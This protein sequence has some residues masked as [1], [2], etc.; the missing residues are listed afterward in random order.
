MTGRERGDLAA[1]AAAGG[2]AGDLLGQSHRQNLGGVPPSRP[3][4][5]QHV[6]GAATRVGLPHA[7]QQGFELVG[8]SVEGRGGSHAH[9]RES[10]TQH[11]C[12][13]AQDPDQSFRRLSPLGGAGGSEVVEDGGKVEVDTAQSSGITAATHCLTETTVVQVGAPTASADIRLGR[14]WYHF[15]AHPR[16]SD[17][18]D[19]ARS[20][21]LQR[22]KGGRRTGGLRMGCG[23]GKHPSADGQPVERG[24]VY[25]PCAGPSAARQTVGVTVGMSRTAGGY[26]VGF[27]CSNGHGEARLIWFVADRPPH[28]T[29]LG[30]GLRGLRRR[31]RVGVVR[32]VD[33]VQRGCRRFVRRA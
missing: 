21:P 23:L 27:F 20:R 3:G 26:R 14:P 1:H 29:L 2:A 33:A 6:R 25:G 5:G 4:G 10:L 16:P 28:E 13:A 17:R 15:E 7:A 9:V 8:K 12:M 11:D 32:V 18:V 30:R 22:T 19:D 24:M 31:E